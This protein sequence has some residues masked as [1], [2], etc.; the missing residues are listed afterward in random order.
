MHLFS[1][2]ICANVVFM[3]ITIP[4]NFD[5]NYAP[6][7]IWIQWTFGCQSVTFRVH[8]ACKLDMEIWHILLSVHNFHAQKLN[9]A[10]DYVILLFDF[11]CEC[12]K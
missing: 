9:Q 5:S 7:Y 2:L 8:V 11:E 12:Y 6:E 4:F 10:V 3:V 1:V